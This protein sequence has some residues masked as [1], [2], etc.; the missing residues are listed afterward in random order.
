MNELGHPYC[1]LSLTVSDS[2]LELTKQP[3]NC[4]LDLIAQAIQLVSNVALV[5]NFEN[6]HYIT[7][8]Q[9]GVYI[10]GH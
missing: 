7:Y 10:M 8:R 4:R 6:L 1:L 3:V 2:D 5:R 9:A